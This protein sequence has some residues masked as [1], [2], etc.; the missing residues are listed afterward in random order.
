MDCDTAIGRD[1]AT[2]A[3]C[4]HFKGIDADPYIQWYNNNSFDSKYTGMTFLQGADPEH[5]ENGAAV[6]WSVDSEYVYLAV[7]VRATGWV[8]FGI[9]EAGGMLGADMAIFETANPDILI[10][11]Y[12]TDVRYP[13]VDD[14]TSNW[15]L[16]SSNVDEDGG[17][18]MIEFKRLLDTEDFQDKEIVNDSFSLIPPHRVI[19]AWG[20]SSQFSYHGLNRARGAIEFYGLGDEQATFAMVMEEEAEGSFLVLSR[21]HEIAAI[22]TEYVRTCYSREDIINQGVNDTT[23]LL[24]IV[25]FEP[26]IQEGNEA[27]V[28]HFIVFGAEHNDCESGLY[29]EVVDGWTPGG[30]PASFPL[31]VGVPLFGEDGFQSFM[32]EIH[33]NN[34]ALTAGIIDNSGIRVFWTSQTREEHLGSLQTGDVVFSLKGQPVGDGYSY[35]TFDCPATCS[36]LV[37]TKVTVLREHMHMHE[38]GARMTNEQIRDGEV[39][40]VG[41]VDYFEFDQNGNVAVQQAPFEIWPG[42]SFKTSCYYSGTDRKFGMASQDEMCVVF[43]YY[44]PRQ[45]IYLEAYDF[46]IPWVCGYRLGFLPCGASYEQELLAS[47][48][49]LNRTF[50]TSMGGQCEMGN[51]D[52]TGSTA[53][54]TEDA[55]TQNAP[56]DDDSGS[57]VVG[58]SLLTLLSVFWTW[59]TS[60]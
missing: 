56:T 26:L 15:E 1:G 8:G 19:A 30:G 22:G 51:D 53:A 20:D 21:N 6:H 38:T 58:L 24:N 28:H 4:T 35:H 32:I 49:D 33:Y 2:L 12:T 47:V 10:D 29:F 44:Y 25:G 39:I 5:P 3:V 45:K 48:D 59:H 37:G 36:S 54:P 9:G 41:S 40:R 50:G 42:D 57:A 43:M 23:E 18:L 11:A 13:Q 60:L 7:A 31:N 52:S 17:F 16:L 55:S 34:P 46:E 14:C 27:Y